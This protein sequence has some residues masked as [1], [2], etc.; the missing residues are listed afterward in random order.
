MKTG[1]RREEAPVL[2]ADTRSPSAAHP[3]AW[4]VSQGHQQGPMGRA[5]CST[6]RYP[7]PHAQLQFLGAKVTS[8]L[9]VCSELANLQLHVLHLTVTSFPSLKTSWKLSPAMLSAFLTAIFEKYYFTLKKKRGVV[10]IGESSRRERLERKEMAVLT[11]IG[12]QQ[13]RS[14]RLREKGQRNKAGFPPEGTWQPLLCTSALPCHQNPATTWFIN[15]H[16]PDNFYTSK[17]LEILVSPCKQKW[18]ATWQR[19][20][21]SL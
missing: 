16:K 13:G 14:P 12:T 19:D 15:S 7:A 3:R 18:A 21:T 4:H 2:P 17:N 9:Y 5:A 1:S 10:G 20:I 11:S 8:M 6:P